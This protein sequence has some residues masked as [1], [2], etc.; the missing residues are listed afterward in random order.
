M[1]HLK[2][3][4]ITGI[5]GQDGSFLCEKLLQE[6]YEVYGVCRRNISRTSARIRQELEN[7]KLTPKIV[8]LNLYDYR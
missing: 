6:E 7:K 1:I 4:V 3:A 8:C 2:K 5:F